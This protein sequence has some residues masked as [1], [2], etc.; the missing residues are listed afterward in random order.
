MSSS[1]ANLNDLGRNKTYVVLIIILIILSVIGLILF[2][3]LPKPKIPSAVIPL[4]ISPTVPIVDIS[5]STIPSVTPTPAFQTYT[6]EADNFT[7]IYDPGRKFYQDKEAGGNRYTFSSATG[8]IAVHVGKSWSWTYPDRQ[9]SQSLLV[10]GRPTFIYE[11]S[12][13]TIVDFQSNDQNYTIQCV[14]QGDSARKAE[15][16]KFISDFKLN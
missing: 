14:H 9:F 5:P 2:F 10:S 3:Q 4:D 8:N 16:Q 1:R 6:S 11:I 13:Q 15:C 12:T 7:A